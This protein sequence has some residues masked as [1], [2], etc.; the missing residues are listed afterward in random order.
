MDIDTAPPADTAIADIT[1]ATLT[2]LAVLMPSGGADLQRQLETLNE[3]G[4]LIF[5]L[6][7]GRP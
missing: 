5:R 1:Q 2:D 4:V 3:I 7:A 6:L